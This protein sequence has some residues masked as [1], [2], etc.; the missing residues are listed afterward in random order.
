MDPG[1]HLDTEFRSLGADRA[2]AANRPRS[3]LKRGEDPVAEAFD[4]PAAEAGEV[5]ADETVVALEQGSPAP[6]TKL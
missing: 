2:R 3:A 5:V 4:L 6:V 1:A